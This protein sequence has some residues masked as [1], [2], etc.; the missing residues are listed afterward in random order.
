M[1]L[2]DFRKKHDGQDIYI[3]CS[4]KSCDYLSADFFSNKL[5]LGVNNVYKKFPCNYLLFKEFV[6]KTVFEKADKNTSI[7]YSKHRF[8]DYNSP[9]TKPKLNEFKLD[10]N[11][12]DR[13]IEFEHN[14]NSN[15]HVPNITQ[16]STLFKENTK[17]MVSYSTITSAIHLAYYM[18]AKNIILVGHD[19][20]SIKNENNFE[21]YH[22]QKSLAVVWG[23]NIQQAKSSYKNW[24]SQLAQTTEAIQKILKEQYHVNLISL[25]PFVSLGKAATMVDK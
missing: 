13:C 10:Q 16:I 15:N 6:D 21:G 4:G 20:C 18:G 7:F 23:N 9:L 24:V 14:T 25:N 11:T 17:L 22:D 2:A 8:G 19:C 3:I 1:K 12:M 5:T